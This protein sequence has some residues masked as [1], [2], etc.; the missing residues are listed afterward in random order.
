[1]DCQNSGQVLNLTAF[2]R[3][4]KR[5]VANVSTRFLIFLFAL[6]LTGL[7]CLSFLFYFQDTKNNTSQLWL[8]HA[9]KVLYRAE[10][11]LA[12][13]IDNETGSRGYLLTGK[14]EFLEPLLSSKKIIHNNL[15]ELKKTTIDNP[16]QQAH[17]DS[18]VK[19]IELRL[20]FSDS[21]VLAR[22]DRSLQSAIQLVSSGRGK[23]LTDHVRNIIHQI[24]QEETTLLLERQK[25]TA[26]S[27]LRLRTGVMITFTVLA[28][29]I[30]FL[31]WKERMS[32]S[33]LKKIS[34][35]LLENNKRISYLA[36]IADNIQ[37]PVISTYFDEHN[38]PIITQWNKPAEKLFGWTAEEAV[39]QHIDKI[40]HATNI[41]IKNKDT[42]EPLNE[43]ANSGN[44]EA[45]YLTKFG[46]PVHVLITSSS[47]KNANDHIIGN[48]ILVKDI[49]KRKKTEHDLEMLLWQMDQSNDSIYVLDVNYK[50]LSWNRGAENIYGFSKEE[51]LS[52]N[53]NDLLKTIMTEN[54]L[55]TTRDFINKNDHWEGELKRITKSGEEI[56]VHIS[57]TRI[58]EPDGSTGGYVSLSSDITKAKEAEM[59]LKEF[60][61]FFNH[62]NDLSGI[63][64]AQGHFELINPSF[65]KILGYDREFIENAF[66]DFVH[67]D[68][69]AVTLHEYDKLKAGELV[70][71]FINRYRKKNGAYLWLEWNAS[72]SPVTGKLYC[73]ARDITAR[74]KAEDALTSLNGELENRVL[75]RTEKLATSETRFRSLIENI[76]EGIVLSDKDFNST[77]RS[78]SSEKIMGVI[79]MGDTRHRTHP[80]DAERI[81]E[82]RKEVIQNPGI[83]FVFQGRFLNAQNQ[84]AWIEGTFNNLLNLKGVNAIVT[85]FRD[86]TQRKKSEEII[87]HNLEEKKNMNKELEER[88]GQ[89]TSELKKSNEELES[90]SYS[91]SHDLRSPLRAINSYAKILE[92]DYG[93]ALDVEARRMMHIIYRNANKMG[94]LVDDLLDFSRTGRK[95]L[96]FSLLPMDRIVKEICSELRIEKSGKTVE[97]KIG[98]I[99]PAAGDHAS[100]KQV[101]I[102][103]ISNA[104]KYSG[105]RE[106]IIVEINSVCNLDEIVYSI[107]D[108]GVG[109]DMQYVSNLFNTFQRLH[110]DQ[111]FEGTGIGLAIVKRIVDKHGG[112]VWAE[113]KLNEGATFYFTL[114]KV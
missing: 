73:I 47:L 34:S 31:L 85:N 94:Q 101:W 17:I 75:E 106:K 16:H 39:G 83:P 109:F 43:K 22:S 89:R 49:T 7:A 29:I 93:Q 52:K 91:V 65:K 42:F 19:Y 40:I 1:M 64:N 56:F 87:A 105:S 18:L 108:N 2:Q 15:I 41:E 55:A 11:I 58:K 76:G 84:Y 69:V 100:I 86:I 95:E 96:V 5:S 57:T 3:N 61:H 38:D 33:G 97:F 111:E 103:Y 32:E 50:I 102:N 27:V 51:A 67:P 78:P 113:S 112:R 63:A 92:E 82:I 71:S 25:E 98:K 21:T 26:A 114:N 12:T 53:S 90:F 107:K 6:I 60:E 8:E 46:A 70:I 13:V 81:S 37:D 59:K 10:V 110:T 72:P 77:Y 74:K 20:L 14:R 88:V 35:E 62:S 45:V 104:I 23:F 54:E 99:L 30:I 9:Q 48:L 4:M 28:V 36:T 66:I 44:G 80:E 24:E 68:D 79:P